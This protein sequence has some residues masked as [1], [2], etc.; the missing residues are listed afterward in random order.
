MFIEGIVSQLGC[1]RY[2]KRAIPPDPV[3][4]TAADN[5]N[6]EISTEAP[7]SQNPPVESTEE[8][9]APGAG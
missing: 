5:D 3:D 1:F 4:S 8:D 6:E 7:A 9:G 2:R